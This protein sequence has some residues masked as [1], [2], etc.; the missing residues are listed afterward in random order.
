MV[1]QLAAGPSSLATTLRLMA[2]HD[3]AVEGFQAG[4]VGSSAMPHKVNSRSCERING[5]RAVLAGYL[6][7]CG[8]LAGGQ[9][10]EGDV[11]CSV[12]RRV[13]LPDAMFAIDGLLETFATILLELEIFHGSY[14]CGAGSHGAV[15]GDHDGPDGGG[16]ARGGSR[17]RACGHQGARLGRR[18][19]D[20]QRAARRRC[21]SGWRAMRASA[22]TKP[23]CSPRCAPT[24]GSSARRS[25]RSIPSWPRWTLCCRGLRARAIFAPRQIL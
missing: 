23:D 17:A 7:M 2:G 5:F 10:N 20:A 12:V 24:N 4:Q 14:S 16:E 25:C 3:L 18:A 9:W 8:E 13:A 6:T 11:S 15:S 1:F 21:C 22:S 19:G